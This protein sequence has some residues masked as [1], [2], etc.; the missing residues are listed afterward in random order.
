MPR[1]NLYLLG[2]P[3]VERDGAPVEVDTRK[4]IAL[5]AYLAVT[6]QPH[7]RDALAA[8]LWPDYDQAHARAT[9]RRTLSALNKALGG[10]W[11]DAGRETVSLRREDLWL[12]VEEFGRCV[13]G[14]ARHSPGQDCDA[15]LRPLAEAA[16]LYRGDFMAGFTLR[17]SPSFDDWQFFQ[18]ESLR[19]DLAGALERLVRCHGTRGEYEEAI[20]HARRWLALDPLHEPVHR[21]LMCLFAAAGRRSAALHQYRECVR[22]L[23]K[24][25]GVP[26]LEETTQLYQAIKENADFRLQIGDYSGREQ[27]ASPTTP[28]PGISAQ[29]APGN[30]QSAIS[31]LQSPLVGRDVEWSA[32]LG[33]YGAVGADGHLVVLEGEGG[34][35]KTRLADELLAHVRA[36]GGVTVAVRCYEGETDLAYGPLAAGLRAFVSQ[37]LRPDWHT[38]VPPHWLSEAARLLPEVTLR[39]PALPPPPPL[40]S[41]GAQ[42]RFFEGLSQV[43][44]AVCR[45][46]VPGVLFIDD[47]HWADAASLDLLTYFVRRLKGR[48][49]LVLTTWRSECVP[50]GHR[51][52]QLLAEAQR[53]RTATALTLGRLGPEAVAALVQAAGGVLPA[54][55][56]AQ[57]HRET[58]GLPLFVVEYLASL[59]HG[60]AP[61]G[62]AWPIP[63]SVRDVLHARLAA[64]SE[65]ASQILATAAVIGRSFDF[66]TLREASG[67]GEEE[68]VAAL[69]ELIA[70]GLVTEAGDRRWT[71]GDRK[72][73][74]AVLDRLSPITSSL[75]PVYDFSHEKLR[76]L[77]YEETSLARRRLLH[78]RV[79]DALAARA[80]ARRDA[81]A[82]AGLIAHHYR[83]A[84]QDALAADHF[85]LAGNHARALYA[86]A[87]ALAHYRAALALGHP[88]AAALHE[89]IG[90]L[91]TLRGEYSQALTSYETAAALCDPEGLPA[92]ER[93]LGGVHHRRGAWD[94]AESHFQA[95]LAALEGGPPGE[96]ARVYADWSLT[97]HLAGG[98]EAAARAAELAQRALE[99]AERA[100]DTR[101]L[102]QSHNILGVLA[103]SRDDLESARRHLERSLQLAGALGDQSA[104]IAALNNL[105]LACGAGEHTGSALGFAEEALRLAE[106]L[107]DRHREAAL[108][109]N[110][111]DLLHA[112]GRSVEAMTHLKQAV[113]IYAEIGV[114][115]GAVRPEIW[116][117]AE[118]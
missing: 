116:K 88:A 39:S 71:I 4:A 8:L 74:E 42:N 76:A 41:P 43:L 86:N 109:N 48:P 115:A 16:G 62:G 72:G 99:L 54:G 82:V 56:S 49:V 55:F 46:P 13:A 66:D 91:H 113:A 31:N 14:C 77:V 22:I 69:E 37:P 94:Q 35:G 21:E 34:I 81:G 102:A 73:A 38:E 87:E 9:L 61:S 100:G 47:L 40:D 103:A 63:G 70:V 98:P 118:W 101:A 60:G 85:K 7:S 97:A 50:A 24:E 20:G 30:L 92:I 10:E 52:R 117:L 93:K 17:D 32:L 1:L 3:R 51:L 83:E 112:A 68:A 89:A 18:G 95:A 57:L 104:R 26:P 6:D 75:S 110:L 5:V 33:A 107:G 28:S 114:E 79:A 78:R 27:R 2:A 12:D 65:T 106:V 108:H 45:G 23:E 53:A 111:A 90:D 11:L 44:L 84:G 64:V 15:C 80:H 59:A 36:R 19:R 29:S 67:R 58:E 25:L 96:R 105:A